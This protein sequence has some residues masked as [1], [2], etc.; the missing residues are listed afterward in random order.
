ML[1]LRAGQ[2]LSHVLSCLRRTHTSV[3]D[4]DCLSI[5]QRMEGP[6]GD[7]QVGCMKVWR[8]VLHAITTIQYQTK[9]VSSQ[10]SHLAAHRA[11]IR[12]E[13]SKNNRT[14]RCGGKLGRGREQAQCSGCVCI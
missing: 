9:P 12:L 4:D 5:T 14:T 13:P 2:L 7:V 3:S 6:D 1:V 11:G 10:S 8:P